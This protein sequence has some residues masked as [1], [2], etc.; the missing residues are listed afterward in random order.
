MIFLL[1]DIFD[2]Y[3]NGMYRENADN[4]WVVD[5]VDKKKMD[6]NNFDGF[7]DSL[8]SYEYGLFS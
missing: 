2:A 1:L 8:S 3:N 7:D 6:D 5:S 4:S